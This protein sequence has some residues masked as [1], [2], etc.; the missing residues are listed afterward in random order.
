[1]QFSEILGQEYIKNHLTKSALAGRIPHAQLCVGPEGCGK[2]LVIRSL[3]RQMKSTQ[4]AII[5]CNAQTSAFHVIQ[6]LNQMCSQSTNSSG[7]VFRPK[8]AQRLIIYLKDI[9]LPKPDKY[10][11]I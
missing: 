3:I 8:E 2:N 7:R 10:D 5:N 1:M 9:N 11:T 6:K 4:L